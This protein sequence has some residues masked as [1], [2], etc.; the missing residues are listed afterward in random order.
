MK[1]TINLE[2]ELTEEEFDLV[3]DGFDIDEDESFEM[4]KRDLIVILKTIVK[5]QLGKDNTFEKPVKVNIR[6]D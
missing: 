2:Q 6:I 5:T 4:K 1:L 3:A